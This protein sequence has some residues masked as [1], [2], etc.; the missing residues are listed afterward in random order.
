MC[1]CSHKYIKHRTGFLLC[2]LGHALG[3]GLGVLGGQILNFVRFSV[4][5]FPPISLEG[6]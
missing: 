3:V 6:I 5:L 4:M 2:C 1:V